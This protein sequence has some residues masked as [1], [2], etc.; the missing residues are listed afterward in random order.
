MSDISA[1]LAPILIRGAHLILSRGIFI[2][3]SGVR[4]TARGKLGKYITSNGCH[5]LGSVRVF[6]FVVKHGLLLSLPGLLLA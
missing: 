4:R 2:F 6:Y 1:L 3:L 5:A